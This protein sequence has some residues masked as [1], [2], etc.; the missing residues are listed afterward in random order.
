M[1][2]W[3][4]ACRS[5]AR[6]GLGCPAQLHMHGQYDAAS[7]VLRNAALGIAAQTCLRLRGYLWPRAS[8]TAQLHAVLQNF[9]RR[10]TVCHVNY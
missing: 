4:Q 7:L 2:R 1:L 3:L 6:L 9:L 10:H 5:R 8:L